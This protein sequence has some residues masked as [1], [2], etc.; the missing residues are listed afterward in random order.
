[1]ATCVFLMLPA[2]PKKLTAAAATFHLML[3]LDFKE[4]K[5]GETEQ[6]WSLVKAAKLVLFFQLR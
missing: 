5:A 1:M 2:P 6:C 3:K 4:F